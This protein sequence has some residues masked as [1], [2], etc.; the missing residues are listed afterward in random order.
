[1]AYWSATGASFARVPTRSPLP[2]SSATQDQVE[3]KN[4][5][6]PE[7]EDTAF[8]MSAIPEDSQS[9]MPFQGPRSVGGEGF[10]SSRVVRASEVNTTLEYSGATCSGSY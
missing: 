4:W 7:A 2:A 8:S 1:M 3:S 6:R 10:N 5:N 9:T